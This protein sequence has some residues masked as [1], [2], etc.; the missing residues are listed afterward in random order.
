MLLPFL[1]I[2][3]AIT[4]IQT[5]AGL[6]KGLFPLAGV[7]GT[8][9]FRLLF[10]SLSLWAIWRPWRFKLTIQDLKNLFISFTSCRQLIMKMKQATVTSNYWRTK[11]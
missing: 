3:V 10:A 1:L 7:A 6:A 4:S 2:L 11:L 8:S 5:G 9:T